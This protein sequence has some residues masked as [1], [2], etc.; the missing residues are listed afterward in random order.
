MNTLNVKDLKLDFSNPE[1]DINVVIQGIDDF[2]QSKGN[3]NEMFEKSKT[4]L[5]ILNE[6]VKQRESFK[7]KDFETNQES[8]KEPDWLDHE[9]ANM[10]HP[11]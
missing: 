11:V 9:I 10:G 8:D 6:Y 7:N 4:L 1:F 5:F 2:F 3:I